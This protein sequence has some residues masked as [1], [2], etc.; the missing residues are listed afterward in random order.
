MSLRGKD[1]RCEIDP[2]L[3]EQLR[4]M[5]EFEDRAL[6]NLGARLL[7]RAIAGEWHEFNVLRKRFARC[8]NL[9]QTTDKKEGTS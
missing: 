2:E 1:F 5:A 8:G 9:R 4:L 6:A 7:E 3:H